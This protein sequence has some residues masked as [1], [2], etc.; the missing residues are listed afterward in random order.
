MNHC[1]VQEAKE[2]L[3][4]AEEAA[5][6]KVWSWP[7]RSSDRAQEAWCAQIIDHLIPLKI[8]DIQGWA[9]FWTVLQ[10]VFVFFF[11]CGTCSLMVFELSE[12]WEK[13]G[14]WGQRPAS[15]KNAG[16][17]TWSDID[18]VA[19]SWAARK[20]EQVQAN[21]ST[22]ALDHCVKIWTVYSRSVLHEWQPDSQVFL[23]ALQ[24]F[25]VR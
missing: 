5:D 21:S 1:R 18:Q 19:G 15:E 25:V 6:R 16:V 24:L 14:N 11:Q 10:F 2:E 4:K 20:D 17:A 8:Q 3:A 12:G 7:C 22:K 9:H 13:E 23:N